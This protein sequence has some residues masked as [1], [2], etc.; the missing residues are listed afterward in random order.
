[1][2]DKEVVRCDFDGAII[3]VPKDVFVEV[4]F[5]MQSDYENNR[6]RNET[7]IIPNQRRNE[8]VC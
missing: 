1:M 7:E 6:S 8:R 4:V 3:M 5:R 2:D